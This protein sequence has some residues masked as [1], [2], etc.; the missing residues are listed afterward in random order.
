MNPL[1][2]EQTPPARVLSSPI[3]SGKE[4]KVVNA[5]VITSTES[6]SFDKWLRRPH[7][8]SPVTRNRLNGTGAASAQLRGPLPLR[9][10]T[11]SQ[12]P[13]DAAHVSTNQRLQSG[14]TP[15]LTTGKTA[16]GVTWRTAE[17]SVENPPIH[18]RFRLR[19]SDAQKV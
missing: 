6:I 16:L 3:T 11:K 5:Y 13:T 12:Q 17:L 19:I 8:P 15:M 18:P 7:A 9:L 10:V 2:C 4:L 1:K 14:G